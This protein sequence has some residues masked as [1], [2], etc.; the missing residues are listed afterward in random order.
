[1]FKNIA[2]QM[3]EKHSVKNV[4]KPIFSECLLNLQTYLNKDGD[5]QQQGILDDFVKNCPTCN[6]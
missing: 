2:E 6:P 1:M 5:E 3:F 4:F